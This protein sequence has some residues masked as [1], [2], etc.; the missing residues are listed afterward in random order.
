[1]Y[2]VMEM[3]SGTVTRTSVSLLFSNDLVHR[4]QVCGNPL[5]KIRYSY[6][7]IA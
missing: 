5:Y 7:Y 1:M 6:Y 2:Q 3:H 4:Y